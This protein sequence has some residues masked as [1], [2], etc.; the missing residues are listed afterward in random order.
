VVTV[1]HLLADEVRTYLEIHHA[2]VRGLAADHYPQRVIEEWAGPI[3]EQLVERVAANA[4][5]EIRLIAEL[6][7][8]PVGIGAIVPHKS[9]LR[10]CYV[11]SSAA[12]KGVGTALVRAIERIAL[13]HEIKRLHLVASVNSELFYVAMGFDV[14]ERGS[15]LKTKGRSDPA[16]LALDRRA[17][18]VHN[19]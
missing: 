1:R 5:H 10:A 2:S 15:T 11:A 4:D 6:D 13:E 8:V 3:T 14:V 19:L 9:E 18:S 16:S 7:G 12:R 17:H